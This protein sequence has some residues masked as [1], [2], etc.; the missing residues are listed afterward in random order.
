MMWPAAAVPSTFLSIHHRY[1]R[2]R[3]SITALFLPRL[4][5]LNCGPYHQFARTSAGESSNLCLKHQVSSL[6]M[7]IIRA[8]NGT[9]RLE[10]YL[11]KFAAIIL[12]SVLSLVLV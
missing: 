7:V 9:C 11:H 2:V 8:H 6:F 10:A 12:K 1:L 3:T 5:K 4:C